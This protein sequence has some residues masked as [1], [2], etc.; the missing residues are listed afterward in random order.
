MLVVLIVAA[1]GST[2][3]PSASEPGPPVVGRAGDRMFSLELVAGRAI[4]HAGE[5]LHIEASVTY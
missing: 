5:P 4:Y 3:P 1:C 2:A